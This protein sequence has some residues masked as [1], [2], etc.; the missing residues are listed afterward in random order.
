GGSSV[1]LAPGESFERPTRE[2]SRSRSSYLKTEPIVAHGWTATRPCGFRE[3]CKA[4]RESAFQTT[5]LPV[6]VSLEVHADPDQQEVMVQ[7]MKE[8]WG[9]LLL[10]KPLDGCDPKFH[11]PKL[12]DLRNKILIKVK[13][14]A[15]KPFGSLRAAAFGPTASSEE[16][17]SDDEQ[18]TTVSQPSWGS[19]PPNPAEVRPK[20]VAICHNLSSLS[21]YS[22]SQHFKDLDDRIAKKPGHIF[23]VS[24]S[25]IHE[26]AVSNPHD[27]FR[28]NKSFFMRAFPDGTRV[29]SSNPDPSPFWRQ[30]VQMV[31]MN[32]QSFDEGMM[33]NEGMFADEQGW[34]LKPEGYRSLDKDTETHLDAPRVALDLKI[35]VLAGQHIFSLDPNEECEAETRLKHLRPTI[36]CELHFEKIKDKENSAVLECKQRTKTG[37]TDHPDFGKDGCTLSFEGLRDVVEELTFVR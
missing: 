27:I 10:S 19:Q 12:E 16:S 25:R 26:L 21:I 6:I 32:W 29:N 3:V 31:A 9:C 36:K 15:S 8:E 24:E 20:K 28:H 4:V 5:D 34:V 17:V 13:K 30:G 11:A 23:S 1:T 18:S 22:F 33:L 37:E 2:R 7:I 14:P 35:S